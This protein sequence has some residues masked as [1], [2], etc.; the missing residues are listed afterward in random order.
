MLNTEYQNT[1][2]ETK[3]ITL[4]LYMYSYKNGLYM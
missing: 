1:N 4:L 3:S 2:E